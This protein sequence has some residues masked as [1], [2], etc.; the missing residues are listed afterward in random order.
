MGL[1]SFKIT[2][3]HLSVFSA[4]ASMDLLR[5][6]PEINQSS[7]TIRESQLSVLTQKDMTLQ[8]MS[9]IQALQQDMKKVMERLNYL[10]SWA[11]LQVYCFFQQ[12]T[13]MLVYKV[14][15]TALLRKL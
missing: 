5:S 9:T 7:E 2:G 14:Q 11:A 8:V 6:P 15:I 10:E 3:S 13:S 1:T 4:T 12:L